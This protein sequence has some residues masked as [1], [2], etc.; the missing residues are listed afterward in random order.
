MGLP[1]LIVMTQVPAQH[2]DN[3]FVIHPDAIEF[4][5]YIES[6]DLPTQVNG[7]VYLTNALAD[8]FIQ[9]VVFGLVEL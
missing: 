8:P 5:Q 1:V 4:A 9:S 6:L 7:T 3:Q 2:I